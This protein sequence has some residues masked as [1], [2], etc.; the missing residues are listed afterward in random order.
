MENK[1]QEAEDEASQDPGE[2]DHPYDSRLLACTRCGHQQETAWMQLRATV[3]YRAVYCR[4]CGK[5][6]LSARNKCQCNVIWHQCKE[7]RIDPKVHKSRKGKRKEGNTL[8]RVC[9]QKVHNS[10]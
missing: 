9:D 4:N 10:D 3:G 7:H 2:E 8:Q 1:E 6:E 5:Q